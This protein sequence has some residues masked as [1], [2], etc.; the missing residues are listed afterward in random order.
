MKMIRKLFIKLI[1]LLGI[2]YERISLEEGHRRIDEWRFNHLRW[3]LHN[4]IRQC[5]APTD[6]IFILEVGDKYERVHVK[7]ERY[8]PIG[9]NMD[10]IMA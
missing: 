8:E 9:I 2:E 5:Q 1:T 6:G 4:V 7:V 10:R 3:G